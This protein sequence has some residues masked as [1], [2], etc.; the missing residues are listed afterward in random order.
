[1]HH[2]Q[3]KQGFFQ[4]IA[5]SGNWIKRAIKKLNLFHSLSGSRSYFEKNQP[6]NHP[7]SLI[8]YTIAWKLC[9]P[10][11]LCCIFGFLNTSLAVFL[12]LASG[13]TYLS[14]N[15]VRIPRRQATSGAKAIFVEI[16]CLFLKCPKFFWL[17]HLKNFWVWNK[18]QLS[19]N[20]H[21]QRVEGYF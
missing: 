19:S 1:M 4:I 12:M 17:N 3:V 6:C 18:W 16:L 15:L 13:A 9:T 21:F 7:I 14:K 2:I 11:D 5:I 8:T 10:F 20:Y